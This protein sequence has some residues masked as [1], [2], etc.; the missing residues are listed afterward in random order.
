ML[1]REDFVMFGFFT[2]LGRSTSAYLAAR[3][4]R[5][6]EESLSRLLKSGSCEM[7]SAFLACS[8]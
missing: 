2:G 1:E 3:G 5:D 7:H 6:T 4:V 8:L